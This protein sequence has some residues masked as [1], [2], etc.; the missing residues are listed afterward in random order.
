MSGLFKFRFEVKGS[1]TRDAQQRFEFPEIVSSILFGPTLGLTYHKL[2][3][4]TGP[5]VLIYHLHITGSMED[6]GAG[7]SV[8]LPTPVA[9]RSAAQSLPTPTSGGPPSAGVTF[10]SELQA[11]LHA[12]LDGEG[13]NSQVIRVAWSVLGDTLSA[14]HTDGVVRLWKCEFG[15]RGR[16]LN[17]ERD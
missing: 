7:G 17:R 16:R 4:A 14:V 15:N 10:E 12:S 6:G 2:A 5:R 8:D 9:T 1:G 3:V 13:S 11:K